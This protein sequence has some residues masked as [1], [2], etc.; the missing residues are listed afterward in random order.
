MKKVR[1]VF[2][3]LVMTMMI[4]LGG[5]QQV[6]GTVLEN[7]VN[8]ELAVLIT[9]YMSGDKENYNKTNLKQYDVDSLNESKEILENK[10]NDDSFI[11]EVLETCRNNN[12]QATRETV[13]QAIREIINLYNSTIA[14]I[15]GR[16][17][18]G[19]DTTI[20]G[21]QDFIDSAD[22]S[23]TID[24][25]AVQQSVGLI[26]NIFFACGMVIAVVCGVCLGIKFMV[27]STEG[28]AEVKQF[29]LPYVIGCVIIFGAFGIW[30]LVI[31]VMET[32]N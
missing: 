12:V 28:Q 18:S 17:T 27:S 10:L 2:V 15:Q 7:I 9:A 26:Y 31:N 29:L 1:N 21:A 13:Q 19:I 22:T 24:E 3:I 25:T 5:N 32:F 23:G 6:F 8:Q 11:D 30:K 16:D 20:Q 4:I 14:E